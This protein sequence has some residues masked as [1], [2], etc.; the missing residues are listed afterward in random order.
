M[1]IRLP[2]LFFAGLASLGLASVTPVLSTAADPQEVEILARGPVHEA[3]ATTT[4]IEKDP[5]LVRKAPPEAI[6]ELPPDQKPDGDNVQW[7]PGYWHWDEE[8]ADFIWI[9]GFWRVPPPNR[10]WV[11]GSWRE[12]RGGFQWAQGFWQEA[13]PPQAQ[14][15]PS[16]AQVEYLAQPPAQLEVAPSVPSPGET[17]VYVPGTWVWRNR[18]VWRP[19]FWVDHRPGWIWT[20]AHYRWTPAGYI[21]IDGYWD[22]PLA[23]R[24]VLFAPVYVPPGLYARPNYYYSP[25]VVVAEPALYTSLFVRR[26]WGN[27]YFGDY[28]EHRYTQIGFSSWTGGGGGGGGFGVSI[29][30]GRS[31]G[32]DPLWNY[33]RVAH[34]NDTA[35]AVG[36]NNVYTGRYN[37]TVARPPRTLVQQNVVV[38]NITNNVTNVTNNN[39]VIVNNNNTVNNN[40]MMLTNLSNVAAQNKAIALKPIQQQDRVKEQQFAKELRQVSAQRKQAETAIVDRGQV[41]V[42]GNDTPKTAQF[43]VPKTAMLRAQAPAA[44]AK[45]NPVPPPASKLVGQANPENTKPALKPTPVTPMN[46]NTAAQKPDVAKPAPTTPM[47]NPTPGPAPAPTPKPIAP[48]PAPTPKPVTPAPAPTPKPLTPTPT[49]APAPTPKPLTPTPAPAPT[50]KPVTPAPLPAPVPTPAPKPLVPAP[51][52]KPLTPA[53]APTPAPI[54]APKP[55]APAPTA[56]KPL[57][58]APAPLPAPKPMASFSPP[59]APTA[60]RI[61][62]RPVPAA[63]VAPTPTAKPAPIAA[64]A[65]VA[66]P[67]TPPPA[68]KPAPAHGEKGEK[69]NGN[70]G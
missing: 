53:P 22:M 31:V 37:G 8:R 21:F 49:P 20:P 4:E 29:S 67:M 2:R 1:R 32:Y 16:Q 44:N 24:G 28:Y 61:E 36:I 18:Y 17:Y 65:P 68:A 15:Q 19:G 54:P 39:T 45:A 40:Q 46:P 9:S 27:Y 69:K 33:Y 34:R 60:Q 47:P 57:A 42:K 59:P 56:P 63:P 38:N 43:D 13:V 3:F 26:G 52:P 50:P 48:A 14:I 62:P 11:A 41:P 12:V 23:N 55:V 35:W 10:V 7:I 30:V 70:K 58:P 64:P 5:Q 51:A 66:K 25:T 6:E